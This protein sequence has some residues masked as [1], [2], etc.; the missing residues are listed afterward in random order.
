MA[1][2]TRE[3]VCKRGKIGACGGGP[4]THHDG[5][6]GEEEVDELQRGAQVALLVRHVCQDLLVVVGQNGV[7][8]RLHAQGNEGGTGSGSHVPDRALSKQARALNSATR[9]SL[10]SGAVRIM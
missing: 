2:D 7:H 3:Q 6:E 1:R 9:S 10:A 4:A 5:E 8:R